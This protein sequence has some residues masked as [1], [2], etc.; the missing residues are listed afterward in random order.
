M[1]YRKPIFAMAALA[2]LAGCDAKVSDG[3]QAAG[4]AAVSAEGKAEEGKISLKAPGFDLSF[5]V[6]EGLADHVRVDAKSHIVYPGAAIRGM[7]IAAGSKEKKGV[8]ES[9]VEIRFAT[10]DPADRV[11]AWYRDPARAEGFTLTPS[12]RDGDGF[13]I[14]GTSK[15]DGDGFKVRL[16]PKSGGGTEGRL[17]V[18]DAG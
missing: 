17:T 8:G 7:H 1:T 13:V 2:L 9:E 3:N 11:A 18:H 12:A 10:A 16:A 15:S 14:A 6:P 4:N 5:K